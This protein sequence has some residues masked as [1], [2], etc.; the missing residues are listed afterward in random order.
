MNAKKLQ[1]QVD[2]L[3]GELRKANEYIQR[4]ERELEGTPPASTSRPRCIETQKMIYTSSK[5]AH[6]HSRI[7]SNG[8]RMRAYQCDKC[9][10][11]HLTSSSGK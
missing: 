3:K 9:F 11:W 4:L 2:S 10:G 7:R 1:H 8:A 5:D 6:R